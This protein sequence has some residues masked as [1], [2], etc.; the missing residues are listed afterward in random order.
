MATSLFAQ[1]GHVYAWSDY[2]PLGDKKPI[3]AAVTEMGARRVYWQWEQENY[4]PGQRWYPQ[5]MT[6]GTDGGWYLATAVR[7]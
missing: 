2:R 5:S 3:G 4:Q 6:R 7:R 1:R